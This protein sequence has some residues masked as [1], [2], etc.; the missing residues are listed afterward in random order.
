MNRKRGFT[1]IELLVV[2]AIIALLI[3]LLLPALAKARAQAK[4]LKD[5]TQM[6]QIHE[7]WI[8]FSRE[9]EGIFPTPGLID[10][11]PDPE[12]GEMPGRGEED[13]RQNYTAYVHSACI[14]QNYYTPELCVGP[15]EPNANVVI[16]DNYN[17]ESYDVT[18]EVDTYWD[19]YFKTKLSSQCNTSY[20]SMPLVGTR[21]TTEWR[22]TYNSKFAMISNRG[23]PFGEILKDSLTYEIHGGTKQWVGNVCWQ[24]NHVSVENSFLPEGADYS[25]ADGSVADNLFNVDCTSG[26]CDYYGGDI[27]LVILSI[28]SGSEADPIGGKDLQWDDESS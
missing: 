13:F 28:L 23:T 27:W 21:K 5:S 12:F 3:G 15:N 26:S 11:L 14:M 22:E 19:L 6:K 8:V 25:D 2:M 7:A 18:P 17:W 24:D 9:F 1:L 20:A 10:R 4:L 16:M